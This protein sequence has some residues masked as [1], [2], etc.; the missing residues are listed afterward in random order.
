MRSVLVL[1]GATT[2]GV[3][4]CLSCKNDY[5][6]GDADVGGATDGDAHSEPSDAE[7][8]LDADDGACQPTCGAVCCEADQVCFRDAC[9]PDN[10]ACGAGLE[11]CQNDTA[12]VDDVCVPFGVEPLGDW[13][14]SCTREPE[15]LDEFVPQIQCAWPGEYEIDTPESTSVWVPPLVGDLDDDGVPE[16]VFVSSDFD[17]SG[18][19][20]S[21][22]VRAIRGD[23][24]SPLWSSTHSQ[25]ADQPLALADLTGDGQ[26]EVC[27]R[28]NTREGDRVPYCLSSDG[29]LLWEAHDDAGAPVEIAP[30]SYDISLAIA[31]VDGE[32]LPEVVVGLSV[33]DGL[34]GLVSTNTEVPTAGLRDGNGLIA[35]L[36]D[37]NGDG[38]VE[39]LTGGWVHDLVTGETISDWVTS[40]GYTAIAELSVENDG[41]EVVVISP[42]E[43]AGRIRVHALDGMLLFDHEVPG[44]NGGPPAVA[45]FDG[46]GQAEI[47]TAGTEFLTTFDL[48]CVGTDADPPDPTRCFATEDTM[49]GVMWSVEVQEVSS[50]TTGSTVFDFE[51]DGPVEVVYADECWA[52]VFDGATGTVKFSAAHESGTVL[53]HPVIADVDGDFHTEIVVPDSPYPSAA[54]PLDDPLMPGATRD[55]DQVFAGVT[56]YRDQEDRWAPS[57]PLWSQH[58]EHW[59][60]ILD[61]GSVP[62]VEIPS[63]M[64]HN[65]YRQALPMEGTRPID[66]PD[67]TVSD[68]E[69]AEC[70]TEEQ[71]QP[72]SARVCNRGTLPVPASVDVSFRIDGADGEVACT[73]MTGIPLSPGQCTTV[74]CTWLTVPLNEPHDIHAVVDPDDDEGIIECHEDNNSA[75]VGV[76]CPP[77]IN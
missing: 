11:P 21:V 17:G 27:G 45:D 66:S 64:G 1:F 57:R 30:H 37:V 52:R 15:P 63:W 39:A 18:S 36:A 31:N 43:G 9:I 70:D 22:M 24:C 34:T 3:L 49:D 72:I 56:V 71:T 16:I 44:G 61:D 23:D 33:F 40:H 35:A 75:S 25:D 20:G 12:C 74:E 73:A 59:S 28:G 46:D 54:C 42:E 68:L 60:Q 69:A 55:P 26:L 13:D 10:G 6:Y 77:V 50:G 19:V 47:V 29:S 76:Q 53:E 8:D 58:A 65:S 41:P 2:L 14:P 5:V 7:V 4:F 32:G 38:H 51:G 48:D 62:A 67:L